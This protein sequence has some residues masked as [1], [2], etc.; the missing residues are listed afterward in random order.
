MTPLSIAYVATAAVCIAVG[1]QHLLMALRVED[2]K[3]Q[4]LFGLAAFGGAVFL[5]P[6]M[7]DRSRN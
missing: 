7:Y 3:P 6:S 2:R 1:F 4:L 5:I